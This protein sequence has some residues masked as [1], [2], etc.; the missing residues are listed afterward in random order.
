MD[1]ESLSSLIEQNML[2]RYVAL[3]ELLGSDKETFVYANRYNCDDLYLNEE[4]TFKGL[5]TIKNPRQT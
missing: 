5:N 1:N 3:L 2:K 4:V